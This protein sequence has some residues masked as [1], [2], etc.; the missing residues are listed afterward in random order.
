M[1]IQVITYYDVYRNISKVKR[2][3]IMDE[4]INKLAGFGVAGLVLVVVMGVS[5]F[6]GAAAITTALAALG[7]P[8]GMLGGI[9]VLAVLGTLSS[10]VTKYGVD[11]VA[12]EVIRKMLGEG[13]SKSSIIAEI[14]SFPLIT[15]DLRSKL[16][17]FVQRS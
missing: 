10:A 5:G 15:D 8:F 2:K 4:L 16:R 6:A 14:N 17:D 13:R 9:A 11:H 7:G 12:Q 1:T 3:S